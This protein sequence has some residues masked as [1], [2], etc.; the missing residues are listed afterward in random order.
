MEENDRWIDTLQ[1][2]DEFPKIADFSRDEGIEEKPLGL[3]VVNKLRQVMLNRKIGTVLLKL[4]D[5]EKNLMCG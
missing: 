2:Q 3:A 5:E 4:A 1:F